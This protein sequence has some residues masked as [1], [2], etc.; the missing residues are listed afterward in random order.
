MMIIHSKR[1]QRESQTAAL[2][3]KLVPDKINKLEGSWALSASVI[4][5]LLRG[6]LKLLFVL[7][8]DVWQLL[9]QRGQPAASGHGRVT[10]NRNDNKQ[11]TA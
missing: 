6:I 2:L 9:Q 3:N 11:L 5:A 1:I 4:T 8:S 10:D 7:S